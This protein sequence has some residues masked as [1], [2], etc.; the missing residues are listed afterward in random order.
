MCTRSAAF[1]FTPSHRDRL[2]NL[3]G[4]KGNQRPP[5]ARASENGETTAYTAIKWTRLSC[6]TPS[7][8]TSSAFSFHAL[9]YNLGNLMR[10]PEMPNAAEPWSLTS[11]RES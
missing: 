1:H 5:N 11:L 3:L 10:P 4:S 9:T 2:S 6:R 7:P 8:S